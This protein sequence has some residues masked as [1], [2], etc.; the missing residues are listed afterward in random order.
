MQNTYTWL[1]LG[2][3]L[4]AAI[5]LGV[6]FVRPKAAQ[7][8]ATT[9]I[10]TTTVTDLGNGVSVTGSGSYTITPVSGA[11]VPPPSL[12][13]PM[14]FS[15]DLSVD[16]VAALR[17]QETTLI[18]QLKKDSTN[19]GSWMKL[20]TARKI[21]GD[22]QGAADI[23]NYIVAVGSASISYVAYGDLGDLYM[24][25]VKDYTKAEASYKAAISLKPDVIDYYR[26]LYT[27]YHFILKNNVKAEAILQAGLKANPGNG[28]L[29]ELEVEL[30]SGK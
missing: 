29:L 24:N 10:G 19:A 5:V 9:P 12:A 2:I 11:S 20:A 21:A 30:Q 13:R 8:P 25:F 22:Y 1:G 18:A 27:Y 16:A 7:A 15:A 26:A 28:D 17:S 6:F 14:T 4:A 3:I 23:W